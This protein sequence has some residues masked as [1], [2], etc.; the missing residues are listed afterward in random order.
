MEKIS[1]LTAWEHYKYSANGTTAS[2]YNDQVRWDKHFKTF[3]T[4]SLLSDVKLR[5]IL[6]FRIYL[7]KKN[8]SPQTIQHCLGQLRRILRK[9]IQWELYAGPLPLF[10]M[11]KFDNKRTRFLSRNEANHLLGKLQIRSQLWYDVSL[12]AL[13]TGLR[14]SEIFNLKQE[15]VNIDASR[16]YVVD[17]KT[18]KNRAIPLNREVIKIAKNHLNKN[19]KFLFQS[20]KGN[21]ISYVSKIFF[22]VVENCHLNAEVNDR[23][24]RVVFHTLRHTFA[25]WLVQSGSPLAVVSN[26]LGHASIDMTMRYAHLAP[27][28]GADAVQALEK[29]TSLPTNK[30]S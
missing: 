4:D 19:Q 5:N 23:R 9:A 22:E 28:Q 21:Q 11:P 8:L 20:L 27:N 16:V 24:Q 17:T 2:K 12:F 26:L 14:A 15:N 7:Q 6:N 18:S 29:F 3:W 13:H 10:E 30:M 1:V 25:S